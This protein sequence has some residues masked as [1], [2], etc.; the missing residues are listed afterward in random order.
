[1]QRQEEMLPDDNGVELQRQE[2]MLPDDDGV[3]LQRQEEM[4][5]DDD[6][7][8]LQ[9]QEEMLPDDDGV[10]LQRQ[11]EMLPDDDD[12][13]LTSEQMLEQSNGRSPT[14]DVQSS[15][16]AQKYDGQVIYIESYRWRR[17]WLDASKRKGSAYFKSIHQD[18]V[19]DHLGVKWLVKDVGKGNV[20]LESMKY[21]RHYLDAH[22]SKWCKVTY[23]SYPEN[24][25][26]A[27][28]KIEKR[29]GRFFFRS[30]RYPKYRLDAYQSWTSKYWAA[31]TTGRGVYAQFRIYTPPKQDYYKEEFTLDN[32]GRRH[33][34]NFKLDEKI[35]V[36]F[37]NGREISTTLSAELGGEIKKAFSFGLT[38]STTWKTFHSTTYSKETTHTVS[39]TVGPGKILKV[40]QLEGTY[41]H[42]L[43]RAK[44]LKFVTVNVQA[45]TQEVVYANGIE[46]YN[47]G[48]VEQ[49]LDPNAGP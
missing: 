14:A 22:H 6:G 39:T 43:V 47:R 3:E 24:Q 46:E 17:R 37:T 16:Y 40:L 30:D 41:G 20:V 2:E 23:S 42:F 15:Y 5:P 9:R 11:E 35:G 48:E 34:A 38:F 27:R 36:S 7:A 32:S 28:F 8:E 4:L 18:D 26:W 10:E 19:V 45:N 33:E 13:L 49:E 44:R 31:L 1:M 29:K 21:K 25:N 12:T